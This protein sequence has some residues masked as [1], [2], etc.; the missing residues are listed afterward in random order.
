MEIIVDWKVYG[1]FFSFA[2]KVYFMRQSLANRKT[3]E[4]LRA[5]DRCDGRSAL[6]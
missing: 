1:I 6:Q 3:Q 4:A 2:H 5:E